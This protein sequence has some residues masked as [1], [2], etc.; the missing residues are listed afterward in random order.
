MTKE[1][2]KKTNQYKDSLCKFRYFLETVR[3]FMSEQRSPF[4]NISMV[5]ESKN[6]ETEEIFT[7]IIPYTEV[8]K[9]ART[10]ETQ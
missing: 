5:F 3:A 10:G 7:F 6:K 4:E 2:F 9:D 8:W 1:E